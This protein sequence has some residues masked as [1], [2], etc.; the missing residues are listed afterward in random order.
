ME[1]FRLLHQVEGVAKSTTTNII[2]K[3]DVAMEDV[4]LQPSIQFKKIWSDNDLIELEVRVCAENSL[5]LN[6]VYIG[7]NDFDD[8]LKELKAFKGNIHGGIYDLRF[9]EFGPEYGHGAFHARLHFYETGKGLLYISTHQESA[10][11]AFKNGEVASETR[12]YL[13]TEPSLFD[14]FIEEIGA[15]NVGNSDEAKLDCL[16]QE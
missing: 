7:I 5:F 14:R 6:K 15:L 2:K 1:G 4:N 3:H 10:Y 16:S 9:G 8:L 12:M 13:K 11:Q